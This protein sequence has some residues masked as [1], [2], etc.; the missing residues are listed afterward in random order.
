MHKPVGINSMTGR[1][2]CLGHHLAAKYLPA[3][4][5]WRVSSKRAGRFISIDAIKFQHIAQ[6]VGGII[7]IRHRFLSSELSH[8]LALSAQIL[9]LMMHLRPSPGIIGAMEHVMACA[10]LNAGIALQ[11]FVLRALALDTTAIRLQAVGDVLAA[12]VSVMH[13]GGLGDKVPMVIGMRT[14]ALDFSVTPR[15]EMDSV[16]EMDA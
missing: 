15:F 14:F 12:S 11:R 5:W 1:N 13:P 3:G 2:Q 8:T 10:T 7:R 4:L 9:A 6:N 16:F